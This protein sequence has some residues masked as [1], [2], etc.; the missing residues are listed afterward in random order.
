MVFFFK[1]KN[2]VRVRQRKKT[3]YLLFACSGKF[4]SSFKIILGL[5]RLSIGIS[6]RIGVAV[7]KTVLVYVCFGAGD[8]A[9]CVR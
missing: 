2:W 7:V 8:L 5:I 6:I 1:T 4:S 3:L 9:A